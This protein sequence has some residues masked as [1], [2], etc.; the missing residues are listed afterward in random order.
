MIV[1]GI[2]TE[3]P[4]FQNTE[5]FIE[6]L[7]RRGVLAQSELV[8][9]VLDGHP[10]A[11]SPRTLQRHFINTSGITVNYWQ[12]IQRAQR[13][14][15]SLERGVSPHQTAAEAGYFDQAHMTKVLK[16]MMGQTPGEIIRDGAQ[17]TKYLVV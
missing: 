14:M 12:Q 15:I 7:I 9:S 3:I 4:T 16:Q 11:M 8:A 13:A 10:M 6:L 5:N 17:T 2:R 1:N